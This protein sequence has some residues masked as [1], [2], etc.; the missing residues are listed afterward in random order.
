MTFE[1][2]HLGS[3]SSADH[4]ATIFAAIADGAVERE[5]S[6]TLAFDAVDLLRSVKFGALRVP[7]KYGGA[8]LSLVDT[9]ELLIRLAEADSN[10][11]QI[12]R[13]HFGFIE[14]RLHRQN[15]NEKGRWFDLVA[16]GVFFGA[17]MAEL[18][19]KTGTTTSLRRGE[20]GWILDGT[21]YYSTGTIYADWIAAIAA[22]G[23]NRYH[24]AVPTSAP[25]VERLD[26][27][28]GFGQRLT[29]SGTTHFRDVHV[30]DDQIL[31][32]ISTE[33]PPG[34]AY[35]T[36]YYQLFHLATF[37]G[38]AR[39]IL[40]DAREFVLP[41]TRTFGVP[42]KVSQKDDP[43]VQSVIGRLS[44]LSFSINAL[45]R[46]VSEALASASVYWEQGI[47]DH[48]SYANAEIEA[49]QAQQIIVGQILEAATLLFEVGGASATSATRRLDRHWRNA[50][51]L[52]SH[53]P[54]IQRVRELG[55]L[56]LNGTPLGS[57]WRTGTARRSADSQE[58]AGVA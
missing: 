19:D 14:N 6:R 45:T 16:S 38:I 20:S 30:A 3:S 18:D 54:A 17:A 34:N 48:P 28:N 15:E 42:G 29:G 50:R 25:G 51:V 33:N 36:A 27:W 11:P 4:F 58:K 1:T 35:L 32:V 21:K 44:S 13:A 53:N 46:R 8:G 24:V 39:A 52:A 49:F 31:N 9:F 10:L 7:K 41:R 23:E 56:V 43:L 12:I 57:A 2:E 55:D 26:D 5:Q 40:R 22:D 37:S 47:E